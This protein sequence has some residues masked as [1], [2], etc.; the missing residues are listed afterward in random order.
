[1]TTTYLLY[2][3]L[4]VT[5]KEP[6]GENILNVDDSNTERRSKRICARCSFRAA[7]RVACGIVLGACVAVSWAWGTHNAKE[8][9]MRHPTPFFIIWF[10]SIWNVVFFPF[11]YLCQL[12]MERQKEWPTTEFRFENKFSILHYICIILICAFLEL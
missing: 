3:L 11:H 1:M 12:L 4:V 2:V 6:Q 8:T 5:D 10:C 7:R 9:L